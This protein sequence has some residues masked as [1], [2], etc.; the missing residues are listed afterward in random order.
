MLFGKLF[1]SVP[2]AN[3]YTLKFCRTFGRTILVSSGGLKKTLTKSHDYSRLFSKEKRRLKICLGERTGVR[4]SNR[5]FV[6]SSKSFRKQFNNEHVVTNWLQAYFCNLVRADMILPGK[7]AETSSVVEYAVV[8]D[9]VKW[10]FCSFSSTLES[11]VQIVYNL[12]MFS[13]LVTTDVRNK[14]LAA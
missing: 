5:K 14:Y 4:M 1:G 6:T 11:F 2:W 7:S 13:K 10:F 3:R 8:S 12:R 9:W